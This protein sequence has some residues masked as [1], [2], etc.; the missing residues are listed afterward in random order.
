MAVMTTTGSVVRICSDSPTCPTLLIPA[1][2]G[3]PSI[4]ES[5]PIQHDRRARRARRGSTSRLLTLAVASALSLLTWL[6]IIAAVVALAH[7]L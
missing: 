3:G 5:L 2:R 4:A 1:Q 7:T 6:A